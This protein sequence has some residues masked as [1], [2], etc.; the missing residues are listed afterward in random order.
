MTETKDRE[1]LIL[2][3]FIITN[4]QFSV[5]YPLW[6]C[7]SFNFYACIGLQFQ[8]VLFFCFFCII[9]THWMWLQYL[10]LYFLRAS[11]AIE[12]FVY[13]SETSNEGSIENSNSK[14]TDFLFRFSIWIETNFAAYFVIPKI[15]FE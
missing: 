3:N 9:R 7:K 8:W 4:L 11:S 6:G 10:I 5:W 14:W 2:K 15:A 1:A 13:L 12:K